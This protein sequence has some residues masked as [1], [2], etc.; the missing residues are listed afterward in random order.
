MNGK[1]REMHVEEL[2]EAKRAAAAAAHNRKKKKKEEAR[3]RKLAEKKR[4]KFGRG[5]KD[6]ERAKK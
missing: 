6:S 3:E 5:A 4:L 2:R 1:A